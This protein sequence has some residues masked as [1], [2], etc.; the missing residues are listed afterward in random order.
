MAHAHGDGRV[1][2]P[3]RTRRLLTFVSVVLGIATLIGVVLLRSP[4]DVGKR[5]GPDI[6]LISRVYDAPVISTRKGPCANTTAADRVSCVNVRFRLN[7]GPDKHK[8]TSI[9][10]PVSRRPRS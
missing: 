2:I 9:D 1:A 3:R 10:F 6:G 4:G 7:Q 8:T 5:T